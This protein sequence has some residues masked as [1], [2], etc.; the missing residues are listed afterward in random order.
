MKT[1][2]WLSLLITLAL[3]TC[4]SGA[5]PVDTYDNRIYRAYIGDNMDMWLS[6]IKQ[7]ER[8][9][10]SGGDDL[11]LL[12]L[13]VARYGYT[14]YLLGMDKK[15]QAREMLDKTL[16]EA[17]QLEN[18]RYKKEALALKAG[19]NGFEIGLAKHKA[20]ILGRKS[21]KY[22][23]ASLEM[24]R[25]NPLAWTEKGNI[26]YHMPGFFGGS[27]EKAASYYQE[28]VKHFSH[29]PHLPRWLKLNAMVWQ[30]KSLEDNGELLLAATAYRRILREEPRFLWVKNELYPQL[31]E[32][33]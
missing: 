14:G 9:Y 1:L 4:L 27:L 17:N 18:T 11:L 19:I 21:Q 2:F 31:Q 16:K 24:D 32:K 20:P 33:I 8:S 23:N 26:Y 29:N 7:M 30:A 12:H 10:R 13:T 6:T 15:T 28:A 3:S 25:S 22:V 5:S